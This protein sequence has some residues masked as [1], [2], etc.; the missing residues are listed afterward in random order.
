M[1]PE[2]NIFTDNYE[3]PGTQE[4]RNQLYGNRTNEILTRGQRNESS[5]GFQPYVKPYE[6]MNERSSDR[7]P[8]FSSYN[9]PAAP[10]F[11]DNYQKSQYSLYEKSGNTTTAYP[12]SDYS[13]QTYVEPPIKNNRV[14]DISGEDLMP[15]IKT[16]KLIDEQKAAKPAKRVVTR[17]NLDKRGKVM[18]ALYALFVTVLLVAIIISGVMVSNASKRVSALSSQAEQQQEVIAD[19]NTQLKVL[20]NESVIRSEAEK[21]GFVDGGEEITQIK[22]VEFQ[23]PTTYAPVTNWFDKICDWLSGLFGG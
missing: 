23:E 5:S 13:S 15:S 22:T 20:E 18:V 9:E 12:D 17:L 19:Q 10:V 21:L 2:N 8:A 11:N 3:R 7:R 4:A 1:V 14:R 6:G 16:M